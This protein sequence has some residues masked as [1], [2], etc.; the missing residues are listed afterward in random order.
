AS[1]CVE[2]SEQ[3]GIHEVGPRHGGDVVGAR[4]ELGD[5]A[6]LHATG[7]RQRRGRIVELLVLADQQ[8]HRAIDV[9]QFGSR[10]SGGASGGPPGVTHVIASGPPDAPLAIT[11]VTPSAV[12]MASAALA[13]ETALGVT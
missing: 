12:S 9:A 5:D 6:G 4:N 8:Q 13:I 7:A 3:P 10:I 1:A 11:C 2:E